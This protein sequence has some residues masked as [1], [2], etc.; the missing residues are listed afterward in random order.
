MNIDTFSLLDLTV[1]SKALATAVYE[2]PQLPNIAKLQ[3]E[4]KKKLNDNPSYKKAL[5]FEKKAVD[6]GIEDGYSEPDDYYFAIHKG[7][8]YG[9]DRDCVSLLLCFKFRWY[10]NGENYNPHAD[11]NRSRCF[12]DFIPEDAGI[13]DEEDFDPDDI[14]QDPEMVRKWLLDAGYEEKQE[15][16]TIYG[17]FLK[18]YHKQRFS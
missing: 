8:I 2:N 18:V 15:L 16:G 4:I 1:L 6:H 5:V 12:P 9:T 13:E 3:K 10:M 11:N 17:E 7:K 14:Q